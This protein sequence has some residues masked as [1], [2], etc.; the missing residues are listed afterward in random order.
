DKTLR[1]S[2]GRALGADAAGYEI[3]HGVVT[4]DDDAED[5]LGGARAGPVLGT[6]W[7]GSLESDALRTA[8]LRLVDPDFEASGVSFARAREQRLDVLGDLIEEHLDVDALVDL[9]D[10]APAG[11]PAVGGPY[12]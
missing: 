1:L 5:F 8:L 4:V 12:T 6:M 11:L 3:H 9:C 10:G 2:R 7:H